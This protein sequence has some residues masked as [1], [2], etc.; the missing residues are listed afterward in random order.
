MNKQPTALSRRQSTLDS[1]LTIG[2]TVFGLGKES[3]LGRAGSQQDSHCL[4][5]F[6]D[7]HPVVFCQDKALSNLKID[8]N[9]HTKVKQCL[10]TFILD[11]AVIKLLTFFHQSI[12][13]CHLVRQS[14]TA[15][16]S[17]ACQVLIGNCSCLSLSLYGCGHPL[18]K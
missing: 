11:V 3:C 5:E 6:M 17:W 2:N 13:Y 4:S 9:E 10:S 15:T 1:V 12:C 14:A 18:L 16:E 8:I 7:N